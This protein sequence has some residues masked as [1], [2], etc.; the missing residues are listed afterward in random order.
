[1]EQFVEGSE[2]DQFVTGVQKKKDVTLTHVC[3]LTK[4]VMEVIIESTSKTKNQ[5]R[6]G[7]KRQ[8]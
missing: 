6:Y 5:E 8:Q 1:M 7:I 4:N 2:K 3:W